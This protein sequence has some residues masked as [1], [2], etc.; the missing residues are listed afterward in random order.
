MAKEKFFKIHCPKHKSN[1]FIEFRKYEFWEF[2]SKVELSQ[3]TKI[4]I[5]ELTKEEAYNLP[6]FK[7]WA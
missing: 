7:G 1:V 2:I 6:L 3:I 5:I 4:E